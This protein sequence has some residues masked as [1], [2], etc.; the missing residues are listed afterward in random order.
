MRNLKRMPV[1]VFE[2]LWRREGAPFCRKASALGGIE[3]RARA[4]A[5][6]E[7]PFTA[8]SHKNARIWKYT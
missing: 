1:P 6:E 3:M 5:G 8:E 7:P 2:R 4:V